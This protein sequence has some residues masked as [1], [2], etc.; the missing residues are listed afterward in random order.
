M[1]EVVMDTSLE[2]QGQGSRQRPRERLGKQ[3]DA[4]DEIF[5]ITALENR[6]DPS[7]DDSANMGY[8]DLALNIEVGWLSRDNVSFQKVRDRRRVNCMTH[9]CEIQIRTRAINECAVEGHQ[10]YFE[11]RDGLSM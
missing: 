7:C 5:R 8:R 3:V 6:F 9:I 2:E 4:G 11:L 10:E 1:S